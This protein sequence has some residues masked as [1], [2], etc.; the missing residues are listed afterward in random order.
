MLDLSAV[1]AAGSL[2]GITALESENTA[3]E[4]TTSD[5]RAGAVWQEPMCVESEGVNRRASGYC[6]RCLTRVLDI[7]RLVVQA[8]GHDDAGTKEV[9][10]PREGSTM[11]AEA[12]HAGFADMS[13]GVADR[14]SKPAEGRTGW[15]SEAAEELSP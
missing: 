2:A 6:S 14:A 13:R 7:Q 15:Q 11:A 9:N 8:A 4:E 10:V 12:V 1:T 5:V 3:S